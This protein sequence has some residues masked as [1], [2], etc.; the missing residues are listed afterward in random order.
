MQ[1]QKQEP[2]NEI[3]FHSIFNN[4]FYDRNISELPS[5]HSFLFV[6]NVYPP[7]QFIHWHLQC[8]LKPNRIWVHRLNTTNSLW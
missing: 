6:Q 5:K 3:Q 7:V 2:K 8:F 1:L 4:L